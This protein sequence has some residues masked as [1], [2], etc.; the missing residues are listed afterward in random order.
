MNNIFDGASIQKLGRVLVKIAAITPS[1][2]VKNT[3]FM[4]YAFKSLSK[5]A[6]YA[7]KMQRAHD[8]NA[9]VANMLNYEDTQ[10][11]IPWVTWMH[12]DKY[13]VPLVLATWEQK[14]QYNIERR[15]LQVLPEITAQV[16][17]AF[18]GGTLPACKLP[19]NN[20]T[21]WLRETLQNAPCHWYAE[22][23]TIEGMSNS[24][25]D[26]DF[27]TFC[28]EV[29][30]ESA[31]C[32]YNIRDLSIS[33]TDEVHINLKSDLNSVEKISMPP[34]AP[35]LNNLEHTTFLT[36]TLL[37]QACQ[38]TY[39]N[40]IHFYFNDFVLLFTQSHVPK[41]HWI[42][43]LL[44]PHMRYQTVLNNAGL[45][46]HVPND[47]QSN[48]VYSNILFGANLS[49]WSLDTF[50]KNIADKGLGYYVKA[51]H[52]SAC[53][54]TNKLD[55]NLNKSVKSPVGHMQILV[56]KLEVEI[57][58]FVARVIDHCAS[59]EDEKLMAL[60]SDNMLKFL[61]KDCLQGI[62]EENNNI[63]GRFKLIMS[64]YILQA[65]V[66]HGLEHYAMYFW[67]AP[68]N[69]PQ[70][71]RKFFNPNLELADYSYDVDK[72]NGHF[73]HRMFTKY[74]PNIDNQF[75]W[76]SLEYDFENDVLKK[77]SAAFVANVQTLI[78]GY[79]QIALAPARKILEE[80]GIAIDEHCY[81]TPRLIGTS[82]CM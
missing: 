62:S 8:Q 72:A 58:D 79:D 74:T 35:D 32:K 75:N 41:G 59:K 13:V 80:N 64:R 29:E 66:V 45:F 28:N 44:D 43:N 30:H 1:F 33:A 37:Q 54:E 34:T 42:R 31:D 60:I 53:N 73:G 9:A 27:S 7:G 21:W 15:P 2:I 49:S 63:R 26:I 24:T 39:H 38:A 82:I 56:D 23:T 36:L 71:V 57:L 6:N 18:Q 17:Y 69:L 65:G 14:I 3:P 5:I 12:R 4:V 48:E 68:L 50:Q 78:E 55:F 40:W 47:F 16:K 52:S 81:L 11:N 46:S 19:T 77:E 67:L 51:Q 20:L 61:D 70:R 25:I 76:S 22:F 10:Y